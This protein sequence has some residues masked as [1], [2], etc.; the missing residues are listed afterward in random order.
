MSEHL[1]SSFSINNQTEVCN[2]LAFC[3]KVLNELLE[4]CVNKT[5]LVE[6]GVNVL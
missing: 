2:I 6:I 3:K 5:A 4:N 1:L